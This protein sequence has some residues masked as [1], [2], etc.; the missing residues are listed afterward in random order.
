MSA[1][2]ILWL[3]NH[4]TLMK[5]EVKLLRELGYEVYSP[6]LPPFD[7]SIAVDWE[8]DKKLTIPQEAIDTLNQVDFYTEKIPEEAMRVMNEYFQMAIMGVFIEPLKSIVLNYKGTVI[9]HPFGLEDGVSYTGI[10]KQQAGRWLLN[11]IEKLGTRFWFGQGYDNLADIECTFFKE[12][13]IFLPISLLNTDIHDTWTGEKKK[14]LFICPRIKTV[15]YYENIYKEFKKNM[16]DIPH[17]I[18]GAQQLPVTEDS[19]VLGYLPQEEY[20]KL[21]PSHSV[22]FYD[23]QNK[24]HIHYHPF[25]AVR[26]GLPLVYMAGGLLD[27]LGGSDLPGR[28]KTIREARKKC[29]RILSGDRHLADQ[30]RESQKVLLEPLSYHFCRAQWEKEFQKIEESQSCRSQDGIKEKNKKLA[31]VLPLAYKGGVLDYAI[32][33]TIV[34]HRAIE[35]MNEAVKLVFAYPEDRCYE[36]HD[37]F[38]LL[39]NIGVDIRKYSWEMADSKRMQELYGIRGYA[40]ETPWGKHCFCNDRMRYFEDCDAM[41]LASDRVPKAIFSP[42]IRYGVVIHDYIQR[43]VPQMMKDY[44]EWEV[45]ELVRRSEANFTTGKS[46]L[47]DAVQYAG[48]KRK[49]MYQLPRFFEKPEIIKQKGKALKKKYFIWPTNLQKHKNLRIALEALDI[50]YKQGGSFRCYVTGVDTE[51]IKLKEKGKSSKLNA[52]QKMF[53]QSDELR[54]NI[55]I[56][57]YV[58]TERYNCLVQQASFVFHPGFADN[59]NGAVVDAAFLGIPS[60]SSDYA[61]M[62]ELQKELNLT[63]KFFDYH[64]AGAMAKALFYM[65]ENNAELREKSRNN[66]RLNDFSIE[67]KD[68]C[69]KIYDQIKKGLSL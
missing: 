32:R 60:C 47:E 49:K 64:D 38:K 65:E 11:E 33:L 9:F 30:I 48:T 27:R 41:I 63:V 26:C 19:S 52:L 40:E 67:N 6:K 8:A 22:M 25:E 54:K 2:R 15:S 29:K 36:D 69:K 14:L 12:R 59:G 5:S 21:Y 39:R 62:R 3:Y 34:L 18:G 55:E 16:G 46:V 61:A 17:S 28:C 4:N 53:L 37:Y 58:R 13:A 56:L 23:S 50:Y 45:F 66:T 31:I 20:D 42:G 1:K 43:Y 7:V 44:V 35:A 51:K 68:L 24:R 57:G 10:I